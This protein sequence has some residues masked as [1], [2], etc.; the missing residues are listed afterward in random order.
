MIKK[1]FPLITLGCLLGLSTQAHALEG[2][3]L[4]KSKPCVGCHTIDTKLVGPAFKEV[5][6]K[7][8]GQEGA[9]DMLAGKIKNGSKG[10]WGNAAV[11]PPNMVTDEEAKT[12][13]GWILS[14]K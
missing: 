11:M 9:S 10:V 5:S 7:Y 2:E 4:F 6:A 8:A 13:A 12:L 14:L 1:M 3:A